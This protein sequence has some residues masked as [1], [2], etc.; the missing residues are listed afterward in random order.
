MLARVLNALQLT[1]TMR[2]Q[3]TFEKLIKLLGW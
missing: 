2:L 1:V 3:Q